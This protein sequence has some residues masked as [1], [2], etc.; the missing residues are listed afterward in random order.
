MLPWLALVSEWLG[1]GWMVEYGQAPVSWP[2]F[3]G[4]AESLSLRCY[5]AR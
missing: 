3:D 2:Q 1:G 5:T 4:L